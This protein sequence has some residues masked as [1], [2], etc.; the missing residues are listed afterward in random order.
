[1]LTLEGWIVPGDSGRGVSGFFFFFLP[2]HAG[3]CLLPQPPRF[4]SHH[5]WVGLGSE[6]K[7][8]DI[9]AAQAARDWGCLQEQHSSHDPGVRVG[10]HSRWNPDPQP[11]AA[12]DKARSLAA[13][14]VASGNEPSKEVNISPILGCFG[15][16]ESWARRER[17]ELLAFLASSCAE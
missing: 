7:G 4:C 5:V 11:R 17:P 3:F 6:V 10:V 15:L 16:D 1:M 13:D 14:P 9:G 8:R 12:K 2:E